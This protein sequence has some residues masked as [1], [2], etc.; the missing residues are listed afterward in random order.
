MCPVCL[1][2]IGM[3]I[4][5]TTSTAAV[6]TFVARVALPKSHDRNSSTQGEAHERSENRI[7]R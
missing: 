1:A 7:Q 3:M 4:A 2:S 5:A 6:A